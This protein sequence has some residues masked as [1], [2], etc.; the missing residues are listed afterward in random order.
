LVVSFDNAHIQCGRLPSKAKVN[1]WPVTNPARASRGNTAVLSTFRD[2][3]DEIDRRVFA[4]FLDHWRN[5]E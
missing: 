4:L 1:R 2:G 5:V 3:R